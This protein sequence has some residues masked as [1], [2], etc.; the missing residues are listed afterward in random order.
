M[1]DLARA[2]A[3]PLQGHRQLEQ[4][5]LHDLESQNKEAEFNRHNEPEWVVATALFQ[6]CHCTKG[7]LTVGGLTTTANEL[8]ARIGET[9]ALRPRAVGDILRSLRLQTCKLGNLGRGLRITQ[10]ISGQVH[11]LARDLGIKRSDIVNY[12]AVDAGYAGM[13]CKMCDD[14]GLLMREDGTQ[15][16]TVDAFKTLRKKGRA[17]TGLYSE[18]VPHRR[19]SSGTW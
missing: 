2:L 4:Q 10:Q 15:L 17:G 9:Y 7:P 12:E 3:A 19:A 14:Y 1:R 13:P 18:N 8:L 16:R 5:L 11:R 6:E